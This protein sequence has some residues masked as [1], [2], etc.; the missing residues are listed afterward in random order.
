MGSP[1]FTHV[2]AVDLGSNSFHMIVMRLN[3]G[4]LQ[5]VDKLKE[6]IR[7]ADGLDARNRIT[8]EAMTRALACLE[9]FG[10]RLKSMPPGSVR[11]VGTNTLRKA[12]NSDKFITRATEAIGHPIDIIA[13]REEARLIYLG[14][15]HSLADNG[16]QRF[17]MDIGGGSTE[18]ILGQHFKPGRRESLHMGCVV[19]SRR[20]FSNGEITQ[21]AIRR[22]EIAALIELEAIEK[23]YRRH[24]WDRA[25]G[26]SGTILAIH[27]V[28][29]RQGWSNHGI[30]A[31]S[32]KK[33][34]VAL[35]DAGKVENIKL[36][37]LAAER[38]SIFP[39]GVAILS[40]AFEALQ[41]EVMEVSDGALREGVI[42]D[43]LGRIRHE[44]VRESTIE[45]MSTHYRL[46]TEQAQRVTQDAL[47]YYEQV[48]ASWKIA[49]EA[50]EQMLRWACQLHE[51][52][53][54][55]AYS[56]YH[57]HGF[58]MLSHFDMPGFSRGE[59]R[60]LASIVRGHRRKFPQSVIKDLPKPLRKLTE[61]LCILLRLAVLLHRS[62]SDDPLPPVTL[63]AEKNSLELIFPAGWLQ[64]H[65]LFSADLELEAS[66]L[67]SINF[68][69]RYAESQVE[70]T[71]LTG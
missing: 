47:G 1:E 50:S 30:T 6:S 13:G 33:L 26:A 22:A 29:I 67:A 23:E 54:S 4:R 28:V 10:E 8:D 52:G 41:I 3:E 5:V 7:L 48:A 64:N 63:H 40:A 46:N 51:I 36:D 20:F 19:F 17:V 15:S 59:Q 49:D 57:K 69:L 43:L 27:E 65:P 16:D 68:E 2:A 34:K 70:N 32:L 60:M 39:G 53:I 35:V 18:F 11:I 31:D 45:S 55:I 71:S 9:R 44:D 37:G 24:G 14:V 42:Y 21:R 58:Y 61:K 25:I 62:K 38:S 66:Y 56:Q 12:K